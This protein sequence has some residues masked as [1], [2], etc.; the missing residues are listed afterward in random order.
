MTEKR[1]KEIIAYI[2]TLPSVKFIDD[3]EI[4]PEGHITISCNEDFMELDSYERDCEIEYIEDKLYEKYK[5]V[6]DSIA[7]SE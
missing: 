7:I 6:L 2:Q 4:M 1:N 3:L 5:N